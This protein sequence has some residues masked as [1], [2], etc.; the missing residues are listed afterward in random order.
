MK[1]IQHRTLFAAIIV[2]GFVAAYFGSCKKIDLIRIAAINT[3]PVANVSGSSATANGNV[4]DLGTNMT[5]HGFC[6]SKGNIP[7][8]AD[9][10]ENLGKASST[11]DFSQTI[12]GLQQN[13]DYSIRS[14]I[15]DDEGVAYGDTKHF[16]TLGN[17]PTQWL[18]YDDGT[19]ND[20]IGYTTG[21]SFD[22]AIRFPQ[23]AIQD[24]NGGSI[25]K[26]KFFVREGNP[27]EYYVTIWEG[28][29]PELMF[30]EL[31]SNPIING[32]TEYTIMG[33]Y[34]INTNRDLWIGYWVVD[35]PADTYPA[36]V[37]DG[38]AMTG[39][40]DLIS[41][42]GGET[43]ST[44]STIDPPNLDYN[45]NIQAYVQNSK[46]E[47]NLLSGNLQGRNLKKPNVTYRNEE[48]IPQSKNQLKN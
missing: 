26:I 43:W 6:W 48:A 28:D 42:D 17:I 35:S 25:S 20:G 3:E 29:E 10:T 39:L 15:I 41:S 11:G 12:S 33:G 21:G 27:I 23:E 46:G 7:T 2:S 24:L 45:W 16:T 38:P 44:L 4:I 36:G 40:G 34:P 22:V 8:I 13:T 9:N 5:N 1:F 37:D 18:H 30:L 47:L 32:W 31:V 19:N 14:F